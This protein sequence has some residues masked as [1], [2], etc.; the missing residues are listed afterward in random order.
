[1]CE[2]FLALI[3]MARY[4]GSDLLIGAAERE[5][6]NRRRGVRIWELGFEDGEHPLEG[7]PGLVHAH[8][9]PERNNRRPTYS[10]SQ[11]PLLIDTLGLDGLGAARTDESPS[12]GRPAGNGP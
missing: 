6:E 5:R 10:G 2:D 11:L 4:R 3:L 8:R 7:A 1:M 12:T 9:F